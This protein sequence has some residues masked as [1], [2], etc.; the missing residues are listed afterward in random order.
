VQAQ[1]HLRLHIPQ[2]IDQAIVETAIASARIQRD[3]RN[4]ER[5]QRLGDDVA[6]KQR[7]TGRQW[8]RAFDRR[9]R[10]I[11]KMFQ[12]I[13]QATLPAVPQSHECYAH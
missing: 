8:Q 12:E 4:L 9:T 7:V 11:G 2:V 1:Q 10:A 5:A 6:A 13:G 3:V